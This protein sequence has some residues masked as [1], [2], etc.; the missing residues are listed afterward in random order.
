MKLL[1]WLANLIKKFP[2]KSI[3]ITIIMIALLTIGVQN[4]FMATGDDTLV[5]TDTDVYQDNQ[6]IEEEFGG[7]GI[8]VLYESD[9]FLIKYNL[10]LINV[11]KQELKTKI[12]I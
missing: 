7:E 2:M 1:R 8:I 4:I 12:S 5:K 3:F 9:N 10:K 6:M 11:L